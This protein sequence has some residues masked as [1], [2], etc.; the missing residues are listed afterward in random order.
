[1]FF[2]QVKKRGMHLP[3]AGKYDVFIISPAGQPFKNKAEL[4]AY[5]EKEERLNP[6]S[7]PRASFLKG[8]VFG[9]LFSREK[10][11]R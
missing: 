9:E 2:V 10:I 7:P 6:P 4:R 1:M 3:G 8:T 5:L 11:S